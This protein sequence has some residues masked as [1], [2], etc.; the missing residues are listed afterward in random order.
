MLAWFTLIGCGGRSPAASP[1][2][3]SALFKAAEEYGV[4]SASASYLSGEG[5]FYNACC[6]ETAKEDGLFCIGSISKSFVAALALILQQEGSVSL[7]DPIGKW[8]PGLD[9]RNKDTATLGDLLSMRSGIGDYTGDFSSADYFKE[10]CADELIEMGLSES[11]CLL[12]GEFCYSNANILIAEKVLEAAAG[13]DCETLIREKILVPLGLS[14]TFFASE[15]A[16]IASRLVRGHSDTLSAQNQD[17][18]DTSTVWSGLACGMYSNASDMAKWGDALI[19]GDLLSQD[20]KDLLLDFQE[21]GLGSYYGLC[22]ERKKVCGKNVAALT[23][24]VPGYS[25]TVYIGDGYVLAVLCNRS[26]FSG[27][28]VSYSDGAAVEILFLGGF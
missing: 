12:P 21:T 15:K 7:G 8:L 1:A 17:F 16:S 20:S 22:I 5:A 18:T 10:Y 27:K 23:G 2:F 24:S 6:G 3:E 9:F 26:D 25:S 11:A 4:T 28:R 14:N 13:R 19:N